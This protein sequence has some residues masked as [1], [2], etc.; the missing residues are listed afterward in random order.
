MAYPTQHYLLAFG[1]PLYSLDEWSCTLRLSPG[2][3][4]GDLE[5]EQ[6]ACNAI[7]AALS[8]RFT[9]GAAVIQNKASL[10]WVKLNRVGT[11]GKYIRNVT[12]RK[13]VS[14]VATPSGSSTAMPPQVALAATLTTDAARGLASK[15]RIFLP[16]PNAPGD[17]NTGRLQ[18]AQAL[19]AANFV[20]AMINDINNVP[21]VGNVC[22]F[23]KGSTKP[24]ANLPGVSR[25]VNGVR[26]GLALDTMR[27]R[28]HRLPEAPVVATTAIVLP[29]GSF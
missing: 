2:F 16:A 21:G 29:E 5:T 15:G 20:A 24:G 1:G 28:R 7:A 9:G 8:T 13:D 23:S 25:S 14:P 10:A 18:A 22:I 12:V 6:T 11:D 19:A 27:S 4:A 26:V 3:G 17:T